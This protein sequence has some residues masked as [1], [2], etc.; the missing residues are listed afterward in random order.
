VCVCV[1]VCVCACTSV[2]DLL[3][4]KGI[5]QSAKC[6]HTSHH[7]NLGISRQS[8]FLALIAVHTNLPCLFLTFIKTVCRAN[9]TLGFPLLHVTKFACLLSHL[10]SASLSQTSFTEWGQICHGPYTVLWAHSSL[11]TII[12]SSST[13]TYA[14]PP[15]ALRGRVISF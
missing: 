5:Q 6:L 8:S 12:S 1:C 13:V 9:H 15:S 11:L 3:C 2:C 4:K 14:P 7:L 10:M